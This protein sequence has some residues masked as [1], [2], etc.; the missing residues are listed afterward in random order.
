MK[1]D[2][3]MR[4]IHS[5]L[6]LILLLVATG[7]AS[8]QSYYTGINPQSSDEAIAYYTSGLTLASQGMHRDAIDQF[9]KAVVADPY[10]A[11]AYLSLSR[12]YYAINN[13]DF[14]LYYNIKNYE[15]EV[16]RDYTYNYHLAID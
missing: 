6:F 5:C 3:V 12:S 15:L 14:A 11:E 1:G 8:P 7:C 13:Y 2:G 16:A 9:R 4:K 10:F